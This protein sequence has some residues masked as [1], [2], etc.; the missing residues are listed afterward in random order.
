MMT[1]FSKQ[2]QK[3]LIKLAKDVIYSQFHEKQDVE[4][5]IFLE[6]RLTE[7][8]GV[9]VT[10]TEARELRGCIGFP[11]PILPLGVALV[12]AAVAA[13]FHDPRFPPLQEHELEKIEIE[14]TVL[15]KPEEIKV[16]DKQELLKKIKVGRDGLIV[17]QGQ[18]SG[19]L[20]PQVPVEQK[21]DCKTFLEYTCMKA[22][23]EKDAWQNKATKVLK[24]EGQIIH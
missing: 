2:E 21:W 9:F 14:I 12:R 8:S 11:E 4:I 3:A 1:E 17:K 6:K 15:S 18:F 10:L 22:G 23:L 7:S 24:F 20:L 13:A 16:K 19:L 5:P